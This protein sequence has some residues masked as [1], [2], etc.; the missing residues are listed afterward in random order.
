MASL[1]DYDEFG[2]YIGADL[3]SGDEED[4]PVN[5]F[6]LPGPSGAVPLEGYDEDDAMEGAESNALME[7]DGRNLE[8]L[9][10]HFG[11]NCAKNPCIMQSFYMK[12][13]S[14]I[15]LR[16]TYTARMLKLLCKRRMHNPF[17]NP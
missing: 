9:F 3:D 17:Q 7:V 10:G 6:D 5:D 12:T 11:L 8:S 1:D 4:A 14:T 15:Q 2:N 16:K 13:S